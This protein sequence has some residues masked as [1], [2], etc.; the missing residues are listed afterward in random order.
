MAR[1]AW[2]LDTGPD[3]HWLTRGACRQHNPDW[4]TVASRA[5]SAGRKTNRLARAICAT[6]PVRAECRALIEAGLA[7]AG[8]IIAG[9][10]VPWVVRGYRHTQAL[11]ERT[12][13]RCRAPFVAGNSRQVYCA[14]RCQL[15]AFRAKKRADDA[16]S[17]DKVA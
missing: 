1:S 14:R 2:G 6:C 15:A 3:M 8:T 16:A 12:C 4:W 17:L 9:I 11:T 5:D 7:P 13:I 10:E